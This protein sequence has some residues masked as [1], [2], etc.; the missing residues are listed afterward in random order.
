MY[1]RRFHCAQTCTIPPPSSPEG[2]RD[3]RRS[4]ALVFGN[5]PQL[6]RQ[7]HSWG[8]HLQAFST[9]YSRAAPP[10]YL[11]SS[12]CSRRRDTSRSAAQSSPR[13]TV[14][15]RTSPTC[16]RTFSKKNGNSGCNPHSPHPHLASC[17]IKPQ[18]SPEIR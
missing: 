10:S 7:K 9:N 2:R 15:I 16:M 18:L 3:A 11:P 4:L 8:I 5:L 6:S 1:M 12:L 13:L 14:S 17:I